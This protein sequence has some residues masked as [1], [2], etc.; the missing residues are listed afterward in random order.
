MDQNIQID[1][2]RKIRTEQYKL[3]KISDGSGRRLEKRP[4]CGAVEKIRRRRHGRRAVGRRLVHGTGHAASR[5]WIL[6]P[7]P[8]REK[9]RAP[10]GKGCLGRLTA[11]GA[12]RGKVD[13]ATTGRHRLCTNFPSIRRLVSKWTRGF[14]VRGRP[15]NG[16]TF[17]AVG[18]IGPK[19]GR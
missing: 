12:P 4:T 19:M 2:R 7:A 3:R 14:G 18:T 15:G 8:N 17:A 5:R 16:S 6:A 13:G 9:D 10:S 11:A 1:S